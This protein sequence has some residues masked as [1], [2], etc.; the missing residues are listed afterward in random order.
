MAGVLHLNRRLFVLLEQQ[1]SG[2]F[3]LSGVDYRVRAAGGAWSVPRAWGLAINPPCSG[4]C[5]G[6]RRSF[7]TPPTCSGVRSVTDGL[8]T[9]P[10]PVESA[11]ATDARAETRSARRVPSSKVTHSS[12]TCAAD[13]RNSAKTPHPYSEFQPHSTNSSPRS[14]E[15]AAYVRWISSICTNQRNR[16]ANP[17]GG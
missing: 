16:V 17:T 7:S 5:S 11:I 2:G 13:T 1:L 12:R 9:K 10:R 3:G 15:G 14:A 4:G 8:L 6:S